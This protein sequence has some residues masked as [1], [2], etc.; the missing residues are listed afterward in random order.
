MP[1]IVSCF[2]DCHI[3]RRLPAD[4]KG[5]DEWLLLKRATHIRLG[6][7]WQMVSGTIEPGEKAYECA[8]RELVEETGLVPLHFYQA[9]FVNR[10][11]LAATDEVVLT[12]VFAAEVAADAAVTLSEEHTDYE[13]VPPDEALRRYPWPGQREALG[14]IREQ[15]VLNEARPESRLDALLLASGHNMQPT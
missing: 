5:R 11:Y 9:S 13:W 10:F 1:A 12:P 4:G 14:I 6:G 2:V 7:S 8:A 3:F 15:F